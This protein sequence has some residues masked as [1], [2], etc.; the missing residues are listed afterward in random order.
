MTQPLKLIADDFLTEDE[1]N[2][3]V[4]ESVR[5]HLERML[6]A[7]RIDNDNPEL[8]AEETATLRGHIACLKA[9]IALGKKPPPMTANTARSS[10]RHDYGAKYG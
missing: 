2:S 4:W 9:F 8:T 5:R 1:R 6:A 7:K 10:P 3:P